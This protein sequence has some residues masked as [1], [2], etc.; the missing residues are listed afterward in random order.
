LQGLIQ[1]FTHHTQT[2]RRAVDAAWEALAAGSTSSC[3]SGGADDMAPAVPGPSALAAA[4][5]A[6][7]L[8]QQQQW[9]LEQVC[10]C[11]E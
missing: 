3:S 10:V 11:C 6:V 7:A 5:A 4:H 9:D 2:Y 8:T 1:H